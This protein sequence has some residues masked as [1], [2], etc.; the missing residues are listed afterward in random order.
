MPVLGAR[1]R[2]QPNEAFAALDI[3]LSADNLVRIETV[4]A[5]TGVAGTRDDQ[6]QM[7]MLDS[8]RKFASSTA[9]SPTLAAAA[10]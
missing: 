7:Q 4:V 6:H 3:E 1:P 9:S 5:D 2:P 10:R 8:E